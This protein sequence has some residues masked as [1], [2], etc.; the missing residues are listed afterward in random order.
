MSQGKAL[1]ALGIQGEL[2]LILYSMIDRHDEDSDFAPF[3]QSLPKT[4]RTGGHTD[5]SPLPS[6]I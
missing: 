6:H 4:L 1:T 5:S 3:W 2:L